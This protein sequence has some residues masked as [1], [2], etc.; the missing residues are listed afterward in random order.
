[1]K[2]YLKR[3]VKSLLA[4][5]GY[6]IHPLP[7]G[8]N[9]DILYDQKQLLLDVSH[10]IIIELGAHVGG[11]TEALSHIFPSATIYAFEP[12]PELFNQLRRRFDHGQSVKPIPFAV[13]NRSGT[14][15]FYITR[16]AVKHSLLRGTTER[17]R[18]IKSIEVP[19]ITIDEFC[20]QESI[21]EIHILSMDIQ[22]GELQ[23]LG[24]GGS[25]SCIKIDLDYSCRNLL[26]P[27]V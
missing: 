18:P 6:E 25:P 12:N 23:A 2:R 26:S 16:G 14:A 22:G 24:G 11:Y 27:P 5:L 21:R 3:L 9:L 10:P 4:Y 20:Q 8:P 17:T 15:E 7:C 19:T 13:S 1:M